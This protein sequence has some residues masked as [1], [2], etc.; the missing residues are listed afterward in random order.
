MDIIGF[1]LGMG[2]LIGFGTYPALIKRLSM[3]YGSKITSFYSYF[4]A[5]I[6]VIIIFLP[7]VWPF[8]PDS[9]SLFLIIFLGVLGGALV[10]LMF[11]IYKKS[12][13]SVSMPL[14]CLHPVLTITLAMLIFNEPLSLI[15]KFAAFAVLAGAL[16]I[17]TDFNRLFLGIGGLSFSILLKIALL[18]AMFS[19]N[20]LFA[21][22]LVVNIGGAAT[23]LYL[24]F[25]TVIMLFVFTWHKLTVPKKA[26][27]KMFLI[28]GAFISLAVC[29]LFLAIDKI[30]IALTSA[31]NGSSPLI[32][33]LL[34]MFFLK[35]KVKLRQWLGILVIVAG[36]IA[37]SLG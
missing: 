16:I 13:V 31:F 4:L 29:S 14:I 23:T 10:S 37:L 24:H 28:A 17:V 6:P 9:E 30:G 2:V 25:F 35:E 20:A 22:V 19:T 33:A 11:Y 15:Q 26:D 18:I 7:K 1:L 32:G 5:L 36:L 21:K 34:G 12:N 8:F 3:K 27:I